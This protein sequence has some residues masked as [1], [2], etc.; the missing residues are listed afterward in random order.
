MRRAVCEVLASV[1]VGL[2]ALAAV[3]GLERAGVLT[4]LASPIAG[5]ATLYLMALVMDGGVVALEGALR[6]GAVRT[7]GRRGTGP[8]RPR[9]RPARGL[10]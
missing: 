8:R 1:A 9:F 4:A 5:L 7:L 2:A 10:A 6:R 3:S